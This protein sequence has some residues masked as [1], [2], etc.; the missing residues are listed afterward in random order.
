MRQEVFGMNKLI[1]G[2]SFPQSGADTTSFPADQ[3]PS[4]TGGEEAFQKFI[5]MN[6]TYPAAALRSGVVGLVVIAFTVYRDGSIS[7][8]SVEKSVHAALDAEALRVINLTIGKWNPGAREGVLT[9]R[10]KV[11]PVRFGIKKSFDF[12]QTREVNRF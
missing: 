12:N 1:S 10:K 4:F 8:P 11:V 5:K 2:K 9:D 7:E 3:A 6:L